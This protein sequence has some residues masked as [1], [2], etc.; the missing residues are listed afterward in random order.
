MILLSPLLFKVVIEF[1]DQAAAAHAPINQPP[2]L[3]IKEPF[4]SRHNVTHTGLTY[5]VGSIDELEFQ[6]FKK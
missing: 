2:S 1:S 6:S 3:R 5:T 4:E